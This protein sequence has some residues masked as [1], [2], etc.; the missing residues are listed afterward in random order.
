[1]TNP[2]VFVTVCYDLDR[3]PQP[4]WGG[5]CVRDYAEAS[6]W[7]HKVIDVSGTPDVTYRG[8]HA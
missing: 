5:R 1:M 3:E 4:H 2:G 7:V 6:P 8:S